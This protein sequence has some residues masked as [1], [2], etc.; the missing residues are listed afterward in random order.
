M[1]VK[2]LSTATLLICGLLVRADI[3]QAQTT[4]NSTSTVTDTGG[5]QNSVI[6]AN[7]QNTNS[8][9]GQSNSQSII[10]PSIPLSP[11]IQNPVNTEN[12]FG[13]NLG[14]ALNTI[15][16]R[17]TTIYLGITFQPGRTDDHNARM[18]KLKSETQLLESQRQ[19][20]LTQLELLKKQVAEQELR[21][22]RIRSTTPT[23]TK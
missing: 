20:T 15:D 22:Q 5:F 12:D 1:I 16:G 11:V 21:L 19:T 10:Y 18:A 13:L 17:N 14:A 4:T 3:S 7:P 6:Q 9:N 23:P 2:Y 8:Q